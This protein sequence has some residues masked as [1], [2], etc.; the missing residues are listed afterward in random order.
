MASRSMS[1]HYLKKDEN[2]ERNYN[3]MME[4]SDSRI[5]A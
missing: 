5:L 2:D 4:I 1:I 3:N